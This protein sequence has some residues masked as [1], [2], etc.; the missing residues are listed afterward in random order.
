MFNWL[1]SL[2]ENEFEKDIEPYIDDS[3]P[4][5]PD[6][7]DVLHVESADEPDIKPLYLKKFK[8]KGKKRKV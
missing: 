3:I 2:K 7:V 8:M 4:A 6:D 5:N 1:H